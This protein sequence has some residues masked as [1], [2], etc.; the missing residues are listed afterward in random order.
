MLSDRPIW[1]DKTM[2]KLL[3]G[4]LELLRDSREEVSTTEATFVLILQVFTAFVVEHARGLVLVEYPERSAS[5]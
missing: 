5:L 1:V 4:Q 2:Q 3:Q